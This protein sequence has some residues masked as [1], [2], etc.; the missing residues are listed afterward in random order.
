MEHRGLS[1]V[2]EV[3]QDREGHG[4]TFRPGSDVVPAP[5]LGAQD[6]WG[7]L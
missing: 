4:P 2:T 5:P 1:R 3:T 7:P 6:P